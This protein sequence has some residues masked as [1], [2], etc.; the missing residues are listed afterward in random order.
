MF[1]VLPCAIRAMPQRHMCAFTMRLEIYICCGWYF[2]LEQKRLR[3]QQHRYSILLAHIGLGCTSAVEFVS[4]TL[5]A[6]KGK[7]KKTYFP[8]GEAPQGTL[9]LRA[10]LI[11][12][13]TLYITLP[14]V[15]SHIVFWL[16]CIFPLWNVRYLCRQFAVLCRLIW[17]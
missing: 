7:H 12:L 1:T 3:F 9:S 4:S 13:C 10:H 2:F 5:F 14:L 15:M 16:L 17:N 6:T 11:R 8:R